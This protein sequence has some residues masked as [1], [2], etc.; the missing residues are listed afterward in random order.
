MLSWRKFNISK[1]LKWDL[2]S[3]Q[4]RSFRIWVYPHSDPA[5]TISGFLVYAHN[6]DWT[7]VFYMSIG[8]GDL[9]KQNEWTMLR[10]DPG[11]TNGWIISSGDPS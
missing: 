7:N 10:L 4:G 11:T 1:F 5:T 2:S 8:G 9:L 6:D 3:D